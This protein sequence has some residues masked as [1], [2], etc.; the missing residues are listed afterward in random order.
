MSLIPELELSNTVTDQ[1]GDADSV[2]S[3]INKANVPGAFRSAGNKFTAGEFDNQKQGFESNQEAWTRLRDAATNTDPLA[4]VSLIDSAKADLQALQD[5]FATDVEGETDTQS[6]P[7]KEISHP[8]QDFDIGGSDPFGGSISSKPIKGLKGYSTH[9]EKKAP[10]IMSSSSGA[11]KVAQTIGTDS[12][13]APVSNPC[14]FM[15]SSLGSLMGA[16]DGIMD[17]ISQVTNFISGSIN[18]IID[19]VIDEAGNIIGTVSDALES[20]FNDINSAI[21]DAFPDISIPDF[22]GSFPSLG[23]SDIISKA[24]SD[25]NELVGKVGDEISSLL[26]HINL[27]SI[28]IP[29]FTLPNLF[30]DPC[31]ALAF[32]QM[33]SPEAQD[34]KN[35]LQ[36]QKDA[37]AG[38]PRV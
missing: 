18:S 31:A 27:S 35:T 10:Q 37:P 17:G 1:I 30:G 9:I 24:T 32:E 7:G 6:N 5:K 14:G 38:T 15:N 26:D 2:K 33:N 25:L 22:D 23:F 8:F 34:L 13:G 29:S 16:F 21:K 12:S 3:I 28:S 20:V 11:S 19:S 4:D 36:T